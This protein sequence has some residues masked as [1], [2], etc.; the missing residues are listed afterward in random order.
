M[1]FYLFLLFTL[2]PLAELA[3]LIWIGQLTKWWVPFLVV[4]GTGAVG[5]VLARWQGWQVLRQIR[6]EARDGSI[7]A[8]PLIDGFLIFL[9]GILLVTPGVLT[10][11]VGA[12]LLIPPLRTLMKHAVVTWFRRHLELRVNRAAATFRDYGTTR[13]VHRDG[14][15]IID[16]TVVDTRIE[17]VG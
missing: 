7:P 1:L 5:A 16:V 13:G 11:L 8:G 2:V 15:E 10:D 4:V 3:I 9:A 14:D 17:D 6:E 12:T